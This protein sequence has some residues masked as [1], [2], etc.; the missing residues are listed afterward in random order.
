MFRKLVLCTAAAVLLTPLTVSADK[1]SPEEYA[2][3][4]R[5]SHMM[6]IGSN[7][8]PIAGMVK[9]EV[10][11]NDAAIVGFAKDLA[12]VSSINAMRGYTP[13]SDKGKTKAKP[14]IWENLE[15]VEAQFKELSEVTAALAAAQPAEKKAFIAAFKK[16]G[17]S[18][19]GC[20]DDYK[21]KDYLNE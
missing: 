14:E 15:D 17:K 4:Y 1:M 19:K 16:V 13:G 10:P 5:Q 3:K 2:L 20:H 7:M 6:L 11:W 8:G 21:S 12:A 18:C 9:G